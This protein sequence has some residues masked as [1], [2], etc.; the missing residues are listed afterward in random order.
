MSVRSPTPSVAE[1]RAATQPPSL[2][3]RNSGEH[4]AGKLYMRR[5]SPYVTRWLLRTPI[6]ANG[7]AFVRIFFY[8]AFFFTSSLID[9]SMGT[10][11]RAS[12]IFIFLIWRSFSNNMK[13]PCLSGG[14]SAA[15]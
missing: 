10:C 14:S 3:E 1:L 15:K 11:C 4:W 5:L 2:F 8:A 6:S 12:A 7:V 13:S 9:F